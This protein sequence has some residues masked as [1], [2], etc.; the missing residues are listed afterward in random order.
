MRRTYKYR[1][2]PTR[3]QA[4]AL[5]GQLAFACELYN[6]ALEQ[7]RDWWKRGRS[8]GFIEQSRQIKD[9]RLDGMNAWTQHDV[10]RRLDRAFSGFFRR[11][12]R[13][14]TAGY[15]RFR[16]QLR[17]DSLTWQI[18]G[19]GGGASLHDGRL[20]LQG[21]GHIKV[22]WH[23]S[24][25]AEAE[26]KT[27]TVR[28]QGG[29]W[30]ACFQFDG[31]P[32]KTRAKTGRSVGV[33]VGVSTYAALST[34]KHL[35]GPRAVKT[36][37]AKVRRA[38]RSI[39]RKRRGSHRRR[40]QVAR[41][42]RLKEQERCRRLDRAH[43]ISRGLVHRFDLIGLEDLSIQNMVR[44]NRG[45]NREILDQGW[46]VLARCLSYKAEEAGSS[47]VLVDPRHTSQT[48][49]ECGA[50]DRASRDGRRFACTSCGHADNA[51]TNAARNIL[52][53]AEQS[54]ANGERTPLPEER[55][56]RMSRR[57]VA[58]GACHSPHE[59]EGA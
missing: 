41:Y 36:N 49:A 28:R 26:L 35:H 27:V 9:V 20:R 55:N 39:A 38:Q 11:I 57:R 33:D 44:G 3:R 43:K 10:L 12:A 22:R 32:A 17:Y 6:A 50:V 53:R 51:D 52:A 47:L 5:D 46:A 56:P 19:Q 59:S 25:A 42:A 24:W 54:G 21:I 1:L 8:L 34:G 48:C 45:L 2:Y 18:G 13:G 15:P 4:E 23:R 29:K 40:K 30:F 37:A 31:V 7:R 16:S 58:E 14:Q